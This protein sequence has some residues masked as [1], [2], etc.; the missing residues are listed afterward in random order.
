M[1]PPFAPVVGAADED[2]PSTFRADAATPPTPPKGLPTFGALPRAL[3][4][5]L[6]SGLALAPRAELLEETAAGASGRDDAG[7]GPPRGLGLASPGT[8]GAEPPLPPD[9][10]IF[11]AFFASGC[12]APPAALAPAVPSFLAGGAASSGLPMPLSA[13]TA[14]ASLAKTRIPWAIS[15]GEL[16]ALRALACIPKKAALLAKRRSASGTASALRA[17]SAA[18]SSSHTAESCQRRA[19][20]SHEP[21]SS[22]SATSHRE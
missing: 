12:A 17:A 11:E 9:G 8:M 19:D 14:V 2:P 10:A 15:K 4:S 6:P 18:R 16:E 7:D 13:A 22:R 5:A 21:S 3:P 1:P 20:R